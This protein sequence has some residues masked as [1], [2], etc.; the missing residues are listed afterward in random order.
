M[1]ALYFLIALCFSLG[2]LA[3]GSQG[4]TPSAEKPRPN[5]GASLESPR[6]Y[7]VLQRHGGKALIHVSG[8]AGEIA[9]RWKYRLTG[10]ATGGELP[11]DWKDF[12]KTP[13]DGAFSFDVEGEAGG[14]YALEVRGLV[15]AE[16]VAEARVAHVG[17]GEVFV[18]AG[19]SNSANHGSER[20]KPASGMVS[21]FH[22]GTWR[23]AN[24]PQ[25][26]ASGESGSFVPAFGDAVNARW[27]VPI[28]IV[29]TGVGATSVRQWLPKGDRMTNRP[30]INAY[31]RQVQAGTWESTGELFGGLMKQ[32]EALG[33]RGFRAVLWHQGESDA[34][35]ARSGYPA[36]V[37]ITGEQYRQFLTRLIKAS[38]AR[39]GWEVPWFVAQA[40]YHSEKDAADEMFR[41]AQRAVCE[42]GFAH[43]GPDTDA[44]RE[45]FRD[46]VHFNPRGLQEHGKRWAEKVNGWLDTLPAK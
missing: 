2:P 11:G 31:V 3:P 33:P 9:E 7:E 10:R 30:T 26:G 19:Q 42:G 1:K 17:V 20:Q 14:W 22:D 15:G 41:A 21:A 46:G 23:L 43:A 28:G 12:P 8:K 13:A 36:E 27:H 37:Q 16:A 5:S 25:P 35:Q 18:V 38:R 45:E 34:G 6:D 44:L 32:V 39:L 4:Q 40:T 29:A 24:D